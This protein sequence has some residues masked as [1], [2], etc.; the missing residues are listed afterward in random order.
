MTLGSLA[1]TFLDH[2]I[3]ENLHDVIR[4]NTIAA[5]VKMTARTIITT[6]TFNSGPLLGGGGGGS[7]FV[8]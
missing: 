1:R 3:C 2:D 5:I 4:S 8:A 6:T 7:G